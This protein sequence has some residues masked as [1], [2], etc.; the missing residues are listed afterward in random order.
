MKNDD[1]MIKVFP[2]FFLLNYTIITTKN[3]NKIII[4][5]NKKGKA[6]STF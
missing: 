3:K 1:K 5:N 4:N 2:Y 6:K